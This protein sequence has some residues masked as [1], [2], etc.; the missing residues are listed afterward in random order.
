MVQT[1]LTDQKQEGLDRCNDKDGKEEDSGE[2]SLR[3]KRG[4]LFLIG[5]MNDNNIP[6]KTHKIGGQGGVHIWTC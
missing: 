6:G 3:V 5:Q 1:T 2:W 4:R